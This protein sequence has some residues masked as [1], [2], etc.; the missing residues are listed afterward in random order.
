M[1]SQLSIA[2]APVQAGNSSK[3]LNNEIR[4]LF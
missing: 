3:K 4:E 2:L 1:L